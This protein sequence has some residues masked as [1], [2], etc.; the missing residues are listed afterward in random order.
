MRIVLIGEAANHVDDLVHGLT[1]DHDIVTLPTE[2]AHSDAY[3]DAFHAADI[4]VSLRLR[5]D[6]PLPSSIRLF[7]VP[8]AGLDAIDVAAIAEE[9]HICNVYEHEGPVAE[10][11]I[12][13]MLN[14][15]IRLERMR[16]AFASTPWAEVYT[17]RPQHGE[18]SGRTVGFLGHGHIGRSISSRL[19]AFGATMLAIDDYA[20]RDGVV[21]LMSSDR[22]D[23]LLARSDFV[24][25]ACPLTAETRGLVGTHAFTR[26][27]P[28]AVLVNIARA[29]I[30]DEDALYSAL[31]DNLIGGAIL[32]V[33]YTYPNGPDDHVS[34]SRHDFT[35]LP[36]AW[37]TPHAAAWTGELATRRYSII[38]DNI[39]RLTVGQPLR[40]VVRVGL[41]A[42]EGSV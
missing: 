8:G 7:Q 15:Q 9:T 11:V 2:A 13:S 24:I 38:A 27:K 22:Y 29:P 14:W 23:E 6:R 25:V 4:V 34:P 16:D 21:Q 31:R 40:N 41:T 17:A 3:D 37:C 19:A 36:N 18:L 12:A 33:W 1:A 20:E 26:M 30:V 28:T 42:A 10:F 5:R 39:N 35:S 32:D